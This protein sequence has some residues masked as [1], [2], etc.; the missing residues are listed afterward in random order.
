MGAPTGNPE[1]TPAEALPD[2]PEPM[3][4]P[5]P[6]AEEDSERPSRTDYLKTIMPPGK[7]PRAKW[8]I[9]VLLGV[10]VIATLAG[11]GYWFFKHHKTDKPAVSKTTASQSEPPNTTATDTTGSTTHYVSNGNDLNLE[12]DYPN[13]WTITPPSNNNAGDQTITLT[14]PLSNL[15]TDDQTEVGKVVLLVRP[16]TVQLSELSNGASAAQASTQI[17]YSKPTS[18]QHQYPYLTF[19]H[20]GAGA[21]AAF[22]EVVVTG[23]L[24]FT[25][26]EGITPSGL[27]VDPI[28]SASFYR[29]TTQACTGG[30]AIPLSITSTEWQDDPLFQQTL[31]VFES[32]QLR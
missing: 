21:G 31:T 9:F 6:E 3:M 13:D 12:F 4:P 29:C 20:L 25:Q 23:T 30:G 32:M 17:A 10:L 26:G 7:P 18:N 1:E 19:L 27:S 28:I 14:S 11:G 15:T 22:Q 2:K 8:P 24:Q 5:D 16:G